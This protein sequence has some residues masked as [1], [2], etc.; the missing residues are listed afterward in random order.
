VCFVPSDYYLIRTVVIVAKREQAHR[1]YLSGDH[2]L[3]CHPGVRN[4]HGMDH[5]RHH[6]RSLCSMGPLRPLHGHNGSSHHLRSA[7][8]TDDFLLFSYRL[9]TTCQGNI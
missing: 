2:D 4:N 5:E 1:A 7:A 3:D 6:Q 8:G 9:L